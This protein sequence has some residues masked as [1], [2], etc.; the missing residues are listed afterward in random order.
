M[1]LEIVC[2]SIKIGNQGYTWVMA[3]PCLC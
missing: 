2:I 3:M 1:L